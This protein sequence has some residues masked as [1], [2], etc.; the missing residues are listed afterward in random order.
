MLNT[1]TVMG[2]LVKDPELRQTQ[3]G[4]NVCSF[5]IACERDYKPENGER[6]TDFIDCVAWRGTAEFIHNWFRKGSMIIVS[7]RLQIRRWTDNDGQNRRSAEI[8][9]ENVYFGEAKARTQ[10]GGTESGPPRTPSPTEGTRDISE[11]A[12]YANV[13]YVDAGDYDESGLPF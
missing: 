4:T 11:L 2:R 7:G 8:L 1:I 5:S 10:D 3:T 6:E 12:K 9:A 13:K